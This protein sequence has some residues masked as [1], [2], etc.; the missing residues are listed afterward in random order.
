MLSGNMDVRM[1]CV[2]GTVCS[3]TV[4]S[5]MGGGEAEC[6]A[7]RE[8]GWVRTRC[9]LV[10]NSA[11]GGHPGHNSH[12]GISCRLFDSATNQLHCCSGGCRCW[13]LK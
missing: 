1:L 12:A 11:C 2:G 9:H 13:V 5:G 6:W 4:K 10:M 8:G 3:V 7:S